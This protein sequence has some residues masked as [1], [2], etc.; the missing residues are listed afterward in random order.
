[1]TTHTA[2]DPAAVAAHAALSHAKGPKDLSHSEG[3]RF[4]AIDGLRGVAI[5]M[6]TVLHL[7]SRNPDSVPAFLHPFFQFGRCGVS[8][9]FALSG[10]CLYYPI[11]R[12]NEYSVSWSTFYL[13]RAI[14][15][16]P[17]YWIG[18][19]VWG[20]LAYHTISDNLFRHIWTHV[21]FLHPLSADTMFSF[22]GVFWS[23]GTEE[24]FYWLF[25]A[26]T[27]L[28]FRWPWRSLLA[29]ML[30][31]IALQFVI[32]DHAAFGYYSKLLPTRIGEFIIGMVAAT[33]Y[34]K[35]YH[36][37]RKT[38][39][40]IGLAGLVAAPFIHHA[41]EPRN[42]WWWGDIFFAPCWG[43]LI[44]ACVAFPASRITRAFTFKPL[45]AMGIASYSIYVY[46]GM[47][48]VIPQH[49]FPSVPKGS[50]LWWLIASAS[51]LLIGTASYY[52]TEKP[53]IFLRA[54]LRRPIHKARE[55]RPLIA[56]CSPHIASDY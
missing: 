33:L 50:G 35:G 11:I 10:F 43:A 23:L 31:S 26:V 5:L 41:F 54:K 56:G 52:I 28:V 2:P 13:R 18:L 19:I 9:F 53:F 16:L 46:N 4:A 40:V 47:M 8:L 32:A 24:H 34:A 27:L 12:K 39:W 6:V 37:F 36:G 1:M 51:V 25:P 38:A 21:T 20:F 48:D 45:V 49:F 15:I 42:T 3:S 7:F 29:A 17:T 44:Y 14:R 22:H 30:I 55:S